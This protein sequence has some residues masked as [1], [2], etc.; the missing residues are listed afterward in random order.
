VANLPQ[1]ILERNRIIR[2]MRK[3][4]YVRADEAIRKFGTNLRKL[5][6]EK[7]MSMQELADISDVEYSQISRIERGLINTSLSNVFAVAQALEVDPR[8]LF[9]F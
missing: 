1:S 7:G 5:R 9:S 3:T 6:K 2:A 8:E 4:K